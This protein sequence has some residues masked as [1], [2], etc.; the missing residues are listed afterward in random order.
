MP[1]THRTTEK[2]L[3][4][5]AMQARELAGMPESWTWFEWECLPNN[6]PIQVMRVRGAIAPLIQKGKRKGMKNWPARDKATER[7]IY[8]TPRQRQDWLAKWEAAT[9]KCY[10]CQGT[11]QEWAGWDHIKGD[12]FRPCG[13]C[14][15]KGEPQ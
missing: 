13:R 9:G 12:S 8:I 2:R 14:K 10:A 6:G 11:T 15:A 3:D 4:F 1:D 7:E 5:L